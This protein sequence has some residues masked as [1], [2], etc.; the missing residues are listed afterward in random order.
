MSTVSRAGL[1]LEEALRA[2][3]VD[4]RGKTVL[5]IGASTGGFTEAALRA[6]ARKVIAVEKGTNQMKAP[7]RFDERVELHEKTDVFEF[8]LAEKPDVVVADVSFVSL[9]KVLTYARKNLAGRETEYLVML[10]PQFEAKPWQLKDG[11]LKNH[12]MRREVIADFETWLKRNDFVVVSKKDNSLAGRFG[13]IERFYYLRAA[14]T[15]KR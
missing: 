10:K 2:F 15:P 12:K 6:G 11:I 1:K 14:I 8:A 4:L 9:T 5:D 13:N 7:L 3:R